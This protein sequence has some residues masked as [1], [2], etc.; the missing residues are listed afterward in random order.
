MHY[1]GKCIIFDFLYVGRQI[2]SKRPKKYYKLYWHTLC[3]K[4][5]AF[6]VEKKRNLGLDNGIFL[7]IMIVGSR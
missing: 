2:G 3:A 4:N 1:Y 7:Q 5:E 6:I